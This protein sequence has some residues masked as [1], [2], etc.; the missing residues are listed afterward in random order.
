[1]SEMLT[2]RF[3]DN[4]YTNEYGLDTSD[5]ETFKKNPIASLAREICQN[6]IDASDGT[7]PTIV[8][9]HLFHVQ[10]ENIPGINDLQKEIERCYSYKKDSEKEGKAL[11]HMLK[12]INKKEIPCLRISDFHTTGIEGAKENSRDTAFYNLTKGSG[13]SDK[14]AGSGGSKGIGKFAS[15][16]VSDFNTVFYSTLAKDTRAYIG[17]SKLRSRPFQEDKD[18]LTMGI[19][20]Y[21][22]NDKNYPILNDFHLDP[23]FKRPEE[24]L[25]TDVFIIGFKESS[26]WQDQV[27]SKV[28]DS[29]MVAIVR[30]E[31][32]IKVGD[33]KVSQATL[34][35]VLQDNNLL[36]SCSKYERRRI[37]SQYELLQG[38]DGVS[39]NDIEINGQKMATIYLKRYPAEEADRASNQ[40]VMVRYPYMQIKYQ[41]LGAAHNLSG[42]CIIENN[43]LNK[44]LRE[45]ENPQH[46]DW[47]L[48]RL[49]DDKNR[50]RE[51]RE[52]KKALEEGINAFVLETLKDPN[53]KSSD[54]EGAGEY[55]PVQDLEGDSQN[56]VDTNAISLVSQP[57]KRVKSNSPKVEK[58]GENGVGLAFTN[59]STGGN[60]EG[61]TPK[62]KKERKSA[63]SEDTENSSSD[64]GID[65][66]KNGRALRKVPLSGIRFKT[67]I[68][69][70]NN[71]E[72]ACLFIAT[73]DVKNC[74]FAIKMWGEGNDRYDVNIIKASVNGKECLIKDGA[75]T[76]FSLKKGE[77]YRINYQ[78][79]TKEKFASE[80][81]L[82]AYR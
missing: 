73:S 79:E 27:V 46:T 45:T 47:E 32:A 33:I 66:S 34:N 53:A 1:M 15:F 43:E 42:L 3:P 82:Y 25:G 40:C 8:E 16:V 70:K 21:G 64:G 19:G 55:L 75:V 58:S 22:R 81:M 41:R 26:D 12:A 35:N 23:E 50:K 60:I 62:P 61:R 37:V 9:F 13:V 14:A 5:M 68:Q 65:P 2:W 57:I 77:Q 7:K 39:S 72:Y 6:S 20:Y 30:G 51:T 63:P 69:G 76:G 48:R 71:D 31:L 56:T 29:F 10:R 44:R 24:Q 78:V 11:A 49:D 74:E 54:L 4:N 80:V 38:G 52:M 28:L 17:I 67:L 36:N 18:L 59:G